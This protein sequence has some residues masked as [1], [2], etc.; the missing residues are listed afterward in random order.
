MTNEELTKDAKYLLAA[1]Y[2]QYLEQIKLGTLKSDA[3]NIG[4][5]QV[6]KDNLMPEWQLEDVNETCFELKHA[7]FFN[8]TGGSH[9]AYSNSISNKGIVYMEN[10]FKDN[11]SNVFKFMKEIKDLIPFI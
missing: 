1:A 7:G 10:Q 6:I 2:S 9:I 3:K 5:A 11:L 4:H 8:T